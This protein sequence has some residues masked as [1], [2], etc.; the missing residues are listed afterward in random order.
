MAYAA[1]SASA[2][3]VDGC[4]IAAFLRGPARSHRYSVLK[5][6]A[7]SRMDATGTLWERGEWLVPLVTVGG[8]HVVGLTCGALPQFIENEMDKKA[9][10]GAH[11]MEGRAPRPGSTGVSHTPR[12]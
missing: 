3:R 6:L 11:R 10:N 8:T 2:F 9:I 1:H 7:V 4:A 12:V 5:V